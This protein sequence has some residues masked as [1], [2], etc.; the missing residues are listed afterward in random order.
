[1]SETQARPKYWAGP[2][3]KACDITGEAITDCFIDGATTQGPWAN[4]TPKSHK[5]YGR[6]L[7]QGRG[8]KYEKQEDGKW[9]KT[10]G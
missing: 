2:A 9:L 5:K 7:G 1:M 8:Q 6:G 3:P 4:M 10:G